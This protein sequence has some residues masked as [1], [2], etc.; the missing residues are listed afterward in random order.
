MQTAT[1]KYDT[2]NYKKKTYWH[3]IVYGLGLISFIWLIL[4]FIPI[5]ERKKHPMLE[6]NRPLVMAH[7]GGA[8]LAPENTLAAF[9][10][11]TTLGVDVIELD[12][13]LTKDGH[14]VVIHDETIDRTTD[15]SGKVN[16][17]TLAEIQSYDAGFHFVDPDGRHSYRG[18]GVVVPT[19]EAVFQEVP[20]EM[21]FTIEV[22]DTNDP[23]LYEEIGL[24]L[25]DL[26]VAYDVQDKVLIG[27]FDQRILDMMTDISAGK[28]IISAGK[29]EVTKFVLLHKLGLH[30]L[31]KTKVDSIEMPVKVAGVDL[32]DPKLIHAA[33][34][35]GMDVHYWTINNLETMEELLELGV[36]GI[37]SDRPDIMIDLLD[38]R[39]KE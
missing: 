30:T 29:Q 27:S 11:A 19:L 21:R 37:I 39:E 8:G 24:Q 15:G 12:I 17:L 23:D 36:D 3:Y 2:N 5:Q 4:Y 10:H 13:H 16:E 18:Q 38:E 25:W 31:Y 1:E 9:R 14:L 7:R 22:K 34:R 28:A 35:R 20:K 26:L 33:K 32:I 6:M